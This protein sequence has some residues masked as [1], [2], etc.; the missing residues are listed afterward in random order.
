MIS[1]ACPQDEPGAF[2]AR[3]HV[4]DPESGKACDLGP[5]GLVARSPAWWSE[6]GQWH[7]AYLAVNPPGPVGFGRAVFDVL[8]P[9]GDGAGEHR[10][11]TAGMTVCPAE[12]VQVVDGPPLA[13]FAD[14][15]DTALY[16]LDPDGQRFRPVSVSPGGVD[17]LTASRSGDLIA[18][19]V[20]TAYQP[21]D[22]LRRTRAWFARWLG[23]P[24]S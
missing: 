12:L 14:G 18:A 19:R 16:R 3:L 20:S 4:L 15:L 9:D 10:N 17:S 5:A 22:L 23:D 6:G 24:A 21:K 1:W 8:V 7:L 2:T 13:L 11:L